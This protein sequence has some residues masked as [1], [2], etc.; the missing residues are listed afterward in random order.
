MK[1]SV[2][3]FFLIVGLI[4][5][6]VVAGPRISVDNNVF[7]FGNV[8]E[9][10][11]I[12]HSFTLKNTGDEPLEIDDV[13]T[14]CG[15]TTTELSKKLLSPGESVVLDVQFD[16]T[17]YSGWTSKKVY[18][19]SNDAADPRLVIRLTG[20]VGPA[21]NYHISVGDVNY[22]YYL[23]IDLRDPED[24][25]A[26]H[27]AGAM[28]LPYDELSTWV[29]RLPKAVLIVLYDD[30]GSISDQAAEMLSERDFPEAKSLLGGLNEWARQL[31]ERFIVTGD[32]E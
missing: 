20:N 16:T 7:E 10:I 32:D 8:V 11:A 4:S 31:N 27:L 14:P 15:C 6:S 19:D 12:V 22:L 24:Y 1:R 26:A 23:L 21:E 25:Q 2:T 18:V 5:I 17:G 30:D 28:N 3:F 29:E 13:K 9:G